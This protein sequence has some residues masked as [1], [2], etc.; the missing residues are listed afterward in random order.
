MGLFVV[1]SGG[2]SNCRPAFAALAE[3]NQGTDVRGGY[4]GTINVINRLVEADDRN[5]AYRKIRSSVHRSKGGHRPGLVDTCGLPLQIGVGGPVYNSPGIVKVPAY[6]TECS[7]LLHLSGGPGRPQ[8]T[9]L[10]AGGL[11]IP[12]AVGAAA[13]I[14]DAHQ[15]A[16]IGSACHGARGIGVGDGSIF[17]PSHQPAGIGYATLYRTCRVGIC[18]FTFGIDA[19]QSAGEITGAPYGTCSVAAGDIT[20]LVAPC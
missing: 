13:F 14:L 15:A 12:E 1:Y 9:G 19:D 3:S 11:V 10:Q 5:H 17:A 20:A 18:N 16:L 6:R 2:E 7:L 4:F 8:G